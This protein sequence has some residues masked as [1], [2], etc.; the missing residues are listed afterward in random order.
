[1]SRSVR[2][3]LFSLGAFIVVAQD[4][5]DELPRSSISP[6]LTCPHAVEVAGSVGSVIVDVTAGNFNAAVNFP[7]DCYDASL[8]GRIDTS[9][10]QF[11]M[12]KISIPIGASL[13]VEL[14]LSDIFAKTGAGM[15][16]RLQWFPPSYWAVLVIGE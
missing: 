14:S 1:M 7:E 12:A 13:T 5:S 15:R 8:F 6:L 16:R 10:F 3:L 11:A 2:T 4:L 9:S